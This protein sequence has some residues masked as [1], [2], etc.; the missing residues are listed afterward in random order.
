MLFKIKTYIKYKM[1]NHTGFNL[2]VDRIYT[3]LLEQFKLKSSNIDNTKKIIY[4]LILDFNRNSL[5]DEFL[6]DYLWMY[7]KKIHPSF[8]LYD[9]DGT[10][11]LSI[12]NYK[13]FII[14]F[15]II[16]TKYVEDIFFYN[17][18]FSVYY[19]IPLIR[20][21]R[22]EVYILKNIDWD[23]SIKI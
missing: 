22:L 14:V 2:L 5:C 3:I 17:S 21:N 8:I 18:N 15:L 19:N 16:I 7:F 12:I 23:L 13:E 20:L 4:R 11:D 1:E 9:I 6:I 10:D